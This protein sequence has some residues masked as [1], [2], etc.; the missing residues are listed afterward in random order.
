MVPAPYAIQWYDGSLLFS[1]NRGRADKRERHEAICN[2]KA[3]FD[4]SAVANDGPMLGEVDLDVMVVEQNAIETGDSFEHRLFG[5]KQKPAA[6]KIA[7]K[8]R[9]LRWCRDDIH[10]LAPQWF[11]RFY[12]DTDAREFA[13]RRHGR[14]RNLWVMRQ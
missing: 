1:L 12:I 11:G 6:V 9:L 10:Q 3:Q 14:D 7:G 4:S 8:R 13:A 5:D 2:A